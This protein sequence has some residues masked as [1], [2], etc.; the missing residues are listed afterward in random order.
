[1]NYFKGA[2]ALAT[3]LCAVTSANATDK[4]KSD[5][6]AQQEGIQPTPGMITVGTLGRYGLM[7]P[8]FSDDLE[9]LQ[10]ARIGASRTNVNFGKSLPS[11][12]PQPRYRDMDWAFIAPVALMKELPSWG[13][14]ANFLRFSYSGTIG[15]GSHREALENDGRIS[16]AKA[17]FL[18]A[19]DPK[20]IYGIG[21]TYEDSNIDI[22][23]NADTLGS[24]AKSKRKAW[25]ATALYGN[26]FS[27]HWG[28]VAKGEYQWGTTNLYLNQFTSPGVSIPINNLDQ[29]DDRLYF[30]TQLVGTYEDDNPWIPKGWVAHPVVGATFQ[31]NFIK[32]VTNSLG[33]RVSGAVGKAENYGMF[34]AKLDIEKAATPS[35][36]WQFLPRA[37]IGLQHEYV[38]DLDAYLR[39]RTY[40]SMSV[41]IGIM[42]SGQRFDIQYTRYQGLTGKRT[43]QA[44]AAVASIS[45]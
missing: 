41:G 21:V 8:L 29:G 42:K 34:L 37:S 39:E 5:A 43:Q 4:P 16:S 38:N 23:L 25:G 31:R 19:P 14:G 1:M 10:S 20:T 9:G 11:G 7:A 3:I 30:E 22:H 12:T 33:T 32:E 6:P 17:M 45:F 35:P 15:D 36:D 24:Q 40:A 26:E 27:Y 28:V 2:S 13:G 18:H 44:L